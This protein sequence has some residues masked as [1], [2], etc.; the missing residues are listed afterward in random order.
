MF[1]TPTSPSAKG[2]VRLKSIT[3]YTLWLLLLLCIPGSIYSAKIQNFSSVIRV[4]QTVFFQGKFW[5][6][7]SGGLFTIDPTSFESK[8][9]SRLLPLG[10]DV[11][12]TALSIDKNNRLWAATQQGYLFVFASAT[13]WSRIDDF[14]GPAWNIT[15]LETWNDYLL[16]GA[17]QGFSAYHM[18]GL[19]APKN[20]TKFADA[21]S[22]EVTGITV[23]DDTLYVALA[24]T[25]AMLSLQQNQL[26]E[27]N[28]H[29]PFIWT[30]HND[31]RPTTTMLVHN[32]SLHFFT[33]PATLFNDM[34]VTAA[35]QNNLLFGSDTLDIS[36]TIPSPITDIY[37]VGSTGVI[38]GTQQHYSFIISYPQYELARLD[39]EGMTFTIVSKIAVSTTSELWMTPKLSFGGSDPLRPTPSYQGVGRIDSTGRFHLYNGMPWGEYGGYDPGFY[40]IGDNVDFNGIMADPNGTMWF[41]LSGGNIKQFN[42]RTDYWTRIWV[43]GQSSNTFKVLTEDDPWAP[44][45]KCDALAKDSSGKYWFGNWNSFSGGIICYKPKES[46]TASDP[47][48]PPP[49]YRRYFPDNDP[50]FMK[51]PSAINIDHLGVV[52]VGSDEGDFIVFR[53][54]GSTIPQQLDILYTASALVTVY[55]IDSD[56]N[57]THY[58]A[59]GTGLHTFSYANGSPTFSQNPY[60]LNGV[61]AVE[62]ESENVLWVSTASQGV[63]RLDKRTNLRTSYS[64]LNGLASNNIN[65][66]ALD[67]ENGKLWVA[68]EQG[69]SS[70]E[71]PY[72]SQ[73][74]T[75]DHP[76]KATP[77]VISLKNSARQQT[78]ITFS[79]VMPQS[80]I[81]IYST[82]GKLV[83]KIAQSGV[84]SGFGISFSWNPS[85]EL[86]PGTYYATSQALASS[87]EQKRQKPVKILLLP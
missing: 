37:P 55:D 50:L 61:T 84:E 43:S 63:V 32:D 82:S 60:L 31:R 35:D 26:Q 66:L 48:A 81:Y 11:H 83:E 53:D 38:V 56:K 12:F 6:A 74:I 33:E 13:K 67:L 45:G 15:A 49:D 70:I 24:N 86:A 77:N 29:F 30:L 34:V 76:I 5:Q 52:C 75:P 3:M 80:Q 36:T 23:H 71:L 10:A 46:D 65:D 72:S 87:A 4:N 78:T 21:P 9:L 42:P 51:N 25:V 69:V 62:V 54:G 85:P 28:F 58:I 73:T 1:L 59:S 68:H 18:Q 57:G 16:V 64:R 47:G 2:L 14:A 17:T 79:Q 8:N 20:A 19:H 41:G 40:F 39:L 22:A 7:S 44:W 27:Y